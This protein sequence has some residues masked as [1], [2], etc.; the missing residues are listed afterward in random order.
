MYITEDYITKWGKKNNALL[1]T[2]TENNLKTFNFKNQDIFY[3]ILTGNKKITDFYFN[4]ILNIVENRCIVILIE[5]DIIYIEKEWLNNDKLIHCFTWNKPFVHEKMTAIPIGLNFNRHYKSLIQWKQQ[6]SIH[7]NSILEKPKTM[8]FNCSLHTSAERKKLQTIIDTKLYDVCDKLQYIPPISSRVIP[9][10]VE[11][12]IRVDVTNPECYNL[13]LPYKFILSPRGTGMDCHRTWE[14]LMIGLIPIVQSSMIDE[15]YEDLPVIVVGDWKELNMDLLNKEYEKIIEKKKNNQYNYNKLHIEYW[16]HKFE[17]V[18][19]NQF[20]VP[21]IVQNHD[22]HFI[23]YG[24]DT[25]KHARERILKEANDFGIFKTV[26]GFCRDDLSPS[27][28]DEYKDI[29]DKQRGGGYWLWKLDILRQTIHTIK[30]NDFLIYCDA[31]CKLNK[32]G[33]KRLY[34]YFDMFKDTKYG[35]LSFQMIDQPEQYWTISQLFDYFETPQHHKDTGQYLGGILLIRKNTH[36]MNYLSE[37]EK[38]IQYDKYMITDKYNKINQSAVFQDNRHDQS[39]SSLLRKKYGSIVVEGD[40]T[41]ILPFGG[42]QSRKYPFWAIR[43]K[44]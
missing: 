2:R 5:S 7:E 3:A 43:S 41:F 8:C 18:Y 33:I 24:D 12:Q 39:I 44:K 14:A 20:S 21:S 31:G 30:E 35:M 19:I 17:H 36:F 38:C 10:C 40:E 22:I 32:F 15:L 27:F 11:G 23:T 9:S 29:L 13:W 26:R 28:I 16:I 6:T 37:F 34:E 25:F 1:I 4:K 42:I